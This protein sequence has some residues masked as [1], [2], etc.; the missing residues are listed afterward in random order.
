MSDDLD[1]KSPYLRIGGAGRFDI[2]RGTVDY[3]AR[4]RVVAAPAGQDAGDLWVL[5]GVSVP[6]QLSGP[7]EAIDWKIRWSGV[8][9]AAFENQLKDKLAGKLGAKLGTAPTS[10]GAASAPAR[11]TP[12]DKLKSR[13]AVGLDIATDKPWRDRA[14]AAT[15]ATMPLPRS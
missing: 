5:R 15:A 6:V 2:G 12:Q 1:V 3:I 13:A 10:A 8:T 11:T 9:T 7:I 14:S 4:A